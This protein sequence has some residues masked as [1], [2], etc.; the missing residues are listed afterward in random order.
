[1]HFKRDPIAITKAMVPTVPVIITAV[2]SMCTSS[3]VPG[4]ISAKLGFVHQAK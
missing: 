2:C 4:Y 3:Y 1:M